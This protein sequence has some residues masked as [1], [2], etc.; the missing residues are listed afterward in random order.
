MKVDQE[1]LYWLFSSSAQTISTFVAFLIT[2]F[3]LVLNMMDNL[4]L[5]DETLDDIHFKLKNGYYTKV[6][7]LTGITGLAI[8]LSLLMVY[9]NGTEWE[10]KLLLFII[11]IVVNLIA[12]VFGISFVISIINPNKYRNAARAIIEDENLSNESK[13]VDNTTFM[14]EFIRLESEIRNLLVS[15]NL[16]VPY[17]EVPRMAYSFRQMIYALHQNELISRTNLDDLLKVNKYR[18][19]V[20]HGHID[21]IDESILQM[22]KNAQ[23]IIDSI[24]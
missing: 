16:Y 22:V 7:V 21:S 2:G 4:Q 17:G 1:N 10:Y 6:R 20:F 23:A 13:G 18:N 19:L 5:K 12:I 9:I 3:A 11:T 24:R 14:V 15:R 8:V